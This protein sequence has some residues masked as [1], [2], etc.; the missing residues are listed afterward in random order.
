MTNTFDEIIARCG[1][2]QAACAAALGIK[3][4]AVAHW[5]RRGIPLL[6]AVQLERVFGIPKE[7]VRPDIFTIP[8]E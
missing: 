1:G 3:Q 7:A 4:Q 2:S 6:R 8:K 5:R